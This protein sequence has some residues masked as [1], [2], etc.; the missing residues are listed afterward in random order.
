[1]SKEDI[2]NYFNVTPISSGTKLN[3]AHIITMFSVQAII[4][5]MQK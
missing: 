2:K 3:D 1:M 4:I 5:I